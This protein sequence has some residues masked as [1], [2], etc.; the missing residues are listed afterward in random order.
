[1]W[2]FRAL[3]RADTL[4][5]SCLLEEVPSAEPIFTI[6]SKLAEGMLEKRFSSKGL[7]DPIPTRPCSST[8]YKS[9]QPKATRL[10][11]RS[12]DFTAVQAWSCAKRL[13]TS[14]DSF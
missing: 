10:R 1:M 5:L 2:D 9:D 13:P 11:M 8:N 6:C 12:A 4:N 7:Y 3:S 14:L